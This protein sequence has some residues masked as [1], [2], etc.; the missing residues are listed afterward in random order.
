MEDYCYKHLEPKGPLYIARI[1]NSE[2]MSQDEDFYIKICRWEL[3]LKI[4]V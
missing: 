1:S 2:K 4:D 3:Q